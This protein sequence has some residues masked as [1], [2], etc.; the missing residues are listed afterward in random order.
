MATVLLLLLVSFVHV[1]HG[2]PANP[3]L[4]SAL[5]PDPT[6]LP[7]QFTVDQIGLFATAAMK[8]EALLD[9]NEP[10]IDYD[11][12]DYDHPIPPLQIVLSAK[13]HNIFHQ[14]VRRST[15]MWAV[16]G[17]AVDM[18]RSQ[19]LHP[20]SFE[21]FHNADHIYSGSIGLHYETSTSILPINGSSASPRSVQKPSSL[22]VIPTTSTNN[23]L[24]SSPPGVADQPRY[25]ISF[26]LTRQR[27]SVIQDRYVL[28][29][30][31]LL[32]LQMGKADAISI[33]PRIAI[34]RRDLQAW[35]FM[36]QIRP[37]EM[38]QHLHLFQAVAV[39]EAMARF[40]ELKGRWGE[41]TVMLRADGQL[42][43]RGCVTRAIPARRWCGGL[44]PRIGYTD[45]QNQDQVEEIK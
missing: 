14:M 22:A 26:T 5:Q 27:A 41:M 42:L 7:N 19:H 31:I 43:A 30:L 20:L 44:F 13:T 39:V 32:L 18:M 21:V 33:Q 11:F 4:G 3:S 12:T 9:Y 29:A 24:L 34:T 10:L 36:E 25:D 45:A 40:S 35:V 1:T 17:I 6:P 23:V 38:N 15:V 37:S 8:E 16:S 28:R 2:L